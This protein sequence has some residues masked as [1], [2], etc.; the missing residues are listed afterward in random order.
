M[1]E[2]IEIGTTPYEEECAQVGQDGYR[3]QAQKECA[4]YRS[5]LRRVFGEEPDGAR[6]KIKGNS[7]DFGTYFEVACYFDPENEAA[8]TYAY[9]CEAEAPAQWDDAAR[10]E[11]GLPEEEWQCLDPQCPYAA[12]MPYH[13]HQ[14]PQRTGN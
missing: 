2:I 13:S 5:Q 7:H 12:N 10:M 1:Q 9:R 14:G 3:A 8:A 6:L 4:A 11:L